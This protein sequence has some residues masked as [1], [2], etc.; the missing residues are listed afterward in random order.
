MS[1]GKTA[2]RL[3][4]VFEVVR[5]L[6]LALAIVAGAA[7]L[8][9]TGVTVLDILLRL[10]KTGIVGAYDIVRICGVIAI[11]CALPYL[12]AVKGHIA[13]EYFYQRFSRPGRVV[14]DSV[15]RVVALALFGFL[16]YR[17]IHYG[18]SLRA[19]GTLMPTLRVPVFWL[20]LVISF[21]SL[22]ICIVVAYHLVHPGEEMIK[23]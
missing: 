9:M 13:I 20:P 18:L 16:V 15:F 10:F 6:I 8:V 4:P 1:A 3:E 7:I 23:P 12:T 11:A 22:L 19:A 14:L 21:N 5:K 17:N 2:R